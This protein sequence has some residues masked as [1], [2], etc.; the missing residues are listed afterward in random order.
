MS[1]EN[2]DELND[3]GEISTEL[4]EGEVWC[5]GSPHPGPACSSVQ[6]QCFNCSHDYH[7]L[8]TQIETFLKHFICPCLKDATCPCLK[9]RPWII[10]HCNVIH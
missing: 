9:E 2:Y 1:Y 3:I 4:S 10:I 5:C 7:V 8:A 6:L